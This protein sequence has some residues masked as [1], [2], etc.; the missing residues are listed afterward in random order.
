MKL[1]LAHDWLNQIGGAEN[2]LEELVAMFPG[3]PVFTTIYGPAQMPPAYRQWD[4]RA[5]WLNRAPA[6]H[7][8]H[9]PYLPLY[10]AAVRSLDLAGFDV[11]L[12][13]KSGFIHGLK[14]SA[15]QLHICY[16]LAPTRYVWTYGEYAR[17]EGFGRW[18]GAVIGPVINRLR[19]WDYRAA[20]PTPPA[21]GQ[22][23]DHF[24]AISK[25]IQQRI[26]TY[27]KR[28]SVI[29][30]PPVNTGRFQPVDNPAG[31]YYL[32]VSRLIPYKRI[33]LAVQAFSR[34]N[35]RLIVVGDGRDRA[36][37]ESLAGPSVEFKGRLPWDEVVALMANCRAFLF[38]GF[39]D[40]GIAPVEAQAAGR[41]VIALAKGGALDTVL[42]GETGLFFH[43][44]S[45][46]ALIDA[47][48]QF[49]RFSFDPAAARANAERFSI[50]RFRRELGQF[51]AEKWGEFN[52]SI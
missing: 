17:R 39:E 36:Q 20:Q 52:R 16:C 40:F 2:V 18:L 9:Q 1:A 43:E 41:P 3:A 15:G 42:D 48:T 10:P 31:D 26:K 46:E 13:N 14:H 51:V 19:Q 6:V 45:V 34:L 30:Y 8:H 22:G 49:E 11:I 21:G 23:V 25:D 4:I 28:E 24:I 38:P 32:V 7:R 33:D 27:Y 5:S 29:I 37:L 35:K 12:S 50:G 47:I 44:Q